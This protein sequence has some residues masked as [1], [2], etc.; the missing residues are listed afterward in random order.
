MGERKEAGIAEGRGAHTSS[1][2]PPSMAHRR[3]LRVS[4]NPGGGGV[5][6]QHSDAVFTG[7]PHEE[8]AGDP[9]PRAEGTPI[10]GSPGA[11]QERRRFSLVT[12]R[13]RQ[14]P[15]YGR[16]GP[17]APS[18]FPG[19]KPPSPSCTARPTPPSV[20]KAPRAAT[21]CVTPSLRAPLCDSM[22]TPNSSRLA[23]LVSVGLS[24]LSHPSA[25]LLAKASPGASPGLQ[26][27]T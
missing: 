4:W 22:P 19:R 24:E 13:G 14:C 17:P 8:E 5:R 27:G 1:T 11:R 21:P 15:T 25:P 20:T 10:R 6:Q 23:S 26:E 2:L 16:A 12:T 3:N 18:G 9:I 7:T